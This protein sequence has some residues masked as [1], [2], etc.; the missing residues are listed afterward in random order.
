MWYNIPASDNT[1]L[2]LRD[3]SDAVYTHTHERHE[4]ELDNI[5]THNVLHIEGLSP[6]FTTHSFNKKKKKW[7]CVWRRKNCRVVSHPPRRAP[8]AGIFINS[9]PRVCVNFF[10]FFFFAFSQHRLILNLHCVLCA[11]VVVWIRHIIIVIIYFSKVLLWDVERGFQHEFTL[12]NFFSCFIFWSLTTR[13][14]SRIARPKVSFGKS[15]Y[16]YIYMYFLFASRE[17]TCLASVPSSVKPLSSQT[18]SRATRRA[19]TWNSSSCTRR[20]YT[21]VYVLHTRLYILRISK[22]VWFMD[23][24]CKWLLHSLSRRHTLTFLP[25]A[26]VCRRFL[27][28]RAC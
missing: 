5:H 26:C 15:I 23:S 13:H 10:L 16:T 20:R 11:R 6:L 1:H 19:A 28:S 25:R 18:T 27:Y 3:K 14:Q 4:R 17:Q 22:S 21:V 9:P 24:L 8:H 12:K 2:Y 7:V